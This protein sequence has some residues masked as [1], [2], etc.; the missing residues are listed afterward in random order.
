MYFTL[1]GMACDSPVAS[2]ATNHLPIRPAILDLL[3]VT[4]NVQQNVIRIYSNTKEFCTQLFAE[5]T[6]IL[7]MCIE[8]QI[9]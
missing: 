8:A 6:R 1:F 7:R 4:V 3:I 2:N 9:Q 5:P